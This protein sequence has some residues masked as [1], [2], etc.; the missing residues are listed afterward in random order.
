MRNWPL[1]PVIVTLDVA[2]DFRFVGDERIKIL[3]HYPFKEW[4]MKKNKLA[5]PTKSRIVVLPPYN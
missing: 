3:G 5:V 2:S 4:D 1:K